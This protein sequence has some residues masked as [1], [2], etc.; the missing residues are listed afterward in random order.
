MRKRWLPLF[1]FVLLPVAITAYAQTTATYGESQI[2]VTGCGPNHNSADFDTLAQCNVSTGT[3]TFQ[4]APIFAGKV[5]SPPY[6][7]TTC[8]SNKAGMIQWTGTSFLG[9]DGSA[10]QSLGSSGPPPYPIAGVDN[11]GQVIYVAACDVGMTYSTASGCTGTRSTYAWGPNTVET[12]YQSQT[13]GKTNSAGLAALGSSYAAATA[14][15]NLTAHGYSDWYLPASSELVLLYNMKN[16]IGNFYSGSFW[17]STESY[18]YNG[19]TS[20]CWK[21]MGSGS[22]GCSASK[23]GTYYVRCIRRD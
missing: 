8:D 15:E 18:N 19:T 21:N 13:T 10:W 6:S 11:G 16:L 23:L 12:G 14:C 7:A 20:A 9:C 5:T 22:G 4:K 3:G 1:L 2:G 17:T